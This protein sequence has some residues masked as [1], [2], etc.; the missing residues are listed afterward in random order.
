MHQGKFVDAAAHWKKALEINP[1]SPDANYN[2]GHVNLLLGNFE[3]GWKGYEW[4]KKRSGFKL[5]N[6][7]EPELFNQDVN[8]KTILVYD[9]QGLGDAIQF[10]RYLQLLK[11]EGAK[12]IF[13]YDY[14]LAQIFKDIKWIDTHLTN[15]VLNFE[16]DYH[17]SLQSLPLYFKTNLENIPSCIPY[18]FGDQN[19]VKQ[20][21]P[22]IQKNNKF[23]IGIVW[24]GNPK[25]TNDKRR[26]CSL[27]HFEKIIGF[28][29]VQIFS[30]QKGAAI[31]K[32]RE[33][34]LPVI[35]LDGNGLENFQQTASIIE[36]LDL[37]ITVD[38]STAH[39]AGAMGKPVWMLLPFL[40]DWR[41]MLG[42]N[43]SPWYPTMK[44]FRQKSAGDWCGVFEQIK[45]E[46]QKKINNKLYLEN[47]LSKI[48]FLRDSNRSSVHSLCQP[49]DSFNVDSKIENIETMNK[50][51]EQIYLG[52]TSGENFGWGVCSKNLRKELQKFTDVKNIDNTY[53]N[54][55]K[56]SGI[57]F[58][59]L[60]D[61]NLNSLFPH[62][63]DIN[64]GYT[65]FEDL[66]TPTSIENSTKY[67]LIFA[68]SSWCKSKMLE[69]GIYNSEILIQGVDPELFHYTEPNANENL[70]VIFSGGKFEL[71]KGQDLV[72][73]AVKILQA[74]Y[75]DIV[76]VNS[77]YNQFPHSTLTMKHSKH[78]NFELVDGS[79]EQQMNR[80]YKIN[81]L[82]SSRIITLPILPHE[83]LLELYAK[84]DI[85]LFP[86]R[87]EGGT[88]LVLMEYMA[89]GRPVIASYS[90][91][92]TDIIN[93]Q[94]SLMLTDLKEFNLYKDEKLYAKWEE[95]KIDEIVSAIEF[96]Y[97]NRD[98]IKE[99][100]RNAAEFMENF[101][102]TNTAKSLITT[103]EL[104]LN[105]HVSNS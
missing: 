105:M 95:A 1:N 81:G 96:A 29:E 5:L 52:L 43:D 48:K 27:D 102:W 67:D 34:N 40:P 10:V 38:T 65:F 25:H 22:I 13:K 42:R 30:L 66:L 90:S 100:G 88:N 6:F 18:I 87:C 70:F 16:Y 57:L 60:V 76:L 23:N 73:K 47:N 82:D 12:I 72:L 26:S 33:T 44:L 49:V 86:N 74:K 39:L 19:L 53:R 28:D 4:R 36:N 83:K 45:I 11:S 63:A 78:I 75:A 46:L 104:K 50:T 99:I 15:G 92:H 89:S 98:G 101:T 24:A 62:R 14:R 68:G 61:I 55:K 35:D 56:L 3:E 91:G 37:I 103:M 17:I 54:E 9:E 64:I 69:S 8:D 31:N 21:K 59:A 93:N 7:T 58:N 97:G 94:N 79:W 41:W 32:L 51:S 20:L 2:L 77:W 80:I 85:G 71:R 84:T